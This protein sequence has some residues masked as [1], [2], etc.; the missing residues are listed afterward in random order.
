MIYYTRYTYIARYVEGPSRVI[1]SFSPGTSRDYYN[2]SGFYICQPVKTGQVRNCWGT[3]ENLGIT[4]FCL[5]TYWE[6]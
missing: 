3:I 4:N 5:Q 6:F 1:D 2:S